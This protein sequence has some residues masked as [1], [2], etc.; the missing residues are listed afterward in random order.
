MI[1]ARAYSLWV[2]RLAC[3]LAVVLAMQGCRSE[4]RVVYP[5]QPPVSQPGMTQPGAAPGA[6]QG[7]AQPGA[8][9][10]TGPAPVA[11]A[12]A[13]PAPNAAADP[14]NRVDVNFLRGRAQTVLNEL[15]SA[16][17]PAQLQRVQGIPLVF[18]DSV[19]EVNAFAACTSG[20]R[21]AMAITDGLL[22]IEAHLAQAQAADELFGTRK[23]DAYVQFIARNQRP[24]QPI[25]RPP[26]GFFDAAAS[27]DARKLTR[28]AEVLDEQIAFVLGHELAHHYL[29]HLPC[30]QTGA[31]PTA[32]IGHLL[33]SVIPAFNQ[34]NELAADVAGTNNV[35]RVGARRTSGYRLTEGGALLTMRF[36]AGLD[37]ASPVD[38]LF[39][40]E[41]THPSPLIRQPVIAQTAAAFRSTGGALI[42]P[43]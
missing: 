33:S 1:E 32:E 39:G 17:D 29:G 31:I 24:K 20:G 4:Q 35:L 7:T 41:R 25:V 21:S 38:I 30:T 43:F 26:P 14:I 13:G 10:P 12:P 9:A 5:A 27:A 23:V 6:P 15:V 16:L 19:G 2:G 42:W 34:P 3:S 28:Q 18:D 11:P 8:P 22:D 37:Q 36:F 40:F